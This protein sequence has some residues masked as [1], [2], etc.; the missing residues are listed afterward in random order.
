GCVYP[1]VEL[2]PIRGA[3]RAAANDGSSHLIDVFQAVD[4]GSHD[5]LGGSVIYRTPDGEPVKRIRSGVYE[6][7]SSR[8]ALRLVDEKA[9]DSAPTAPGSLEATSSSAN[10]DSPPSVRSALTSLELTQLL[11]RAAVLRNETGQ[12]RKIVAAQVERLKEQCE[13]LNVNCS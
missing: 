4:D 10:V 5:G 8:V 9:H 6:I 1:D 3:L 13:S 12:L 7:E 2:L 11:N